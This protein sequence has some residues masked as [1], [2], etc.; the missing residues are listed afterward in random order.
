MDHTE[1][2]IEELY[3]SKLEQRVVFFFVLVGI[4][5]VT[6]GLLYLIDFIPEKPGTNDAAK[7]ALTKPATTTPAEPAPVAVDP[8]P[9]SITF[10][11]LDKELTIQNPTSDD[12][13]VLD[14]ALLSGVVRHP[15]SADFEHT[16]TIFLL[17]HSSYLPVVHNKNFQAFNGIQ[18]L[19]W[20][21]TIRLRSKD[22]EYVYAVDRVYEAKASSA[23][24]PIAHGVAKLTLAT[25]NSFATKDDRFIVEA[26]LVSS[27]PLRS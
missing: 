9:V 23:E 24:V 6:Y 5:A 16:G 15:D 2:R 13:S 10:D 1:G 17:G 11:S 22:T 25:C 8:Y 27:K 20:G 14:T 26:S 19:K 4:I 3:A 21:D 18:K 7:E 12:V